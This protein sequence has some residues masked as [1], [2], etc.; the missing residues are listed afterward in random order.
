MNRFDEIVQPVTAFGPSA[1]TS[2]IGFYAAGPASAAASD[3]LTAQNKYIQKVRSC[4]YSIIITRLLSAERL[5][6]EIPA[7]DPRPLLVCLEMTVPV[8]IIA[9]LVVLTFTTCTVLS[10]DCSCAP[11]FFQKVYHAGRARKSIVRFE[12][13]KEPPSYVTCDP[14]FTERVYYR[15]V[16]GYSCMTEYL[17]RPVPLL[18]EPACSDRDFYDDYFKRLGMTATPAGWMLQDAKASILLQVRPNVPRL[19]TLEPCWNYFENLGYK[20]TGGREAPRGRAPTPPTAFGTVPSRRTT[21]TARVCSRLTL[22]DITIKCQLVY[23]QVYKTTLSFGCPYYRINADP[24]SQMS[25]GEFSTHAHSSPNI[26]LCVSK[27]SGAPLHHPRASLHERFS[28]L[29]VHSFLD[30]K[31]YCESIFLPKRSATNW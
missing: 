2:F 12:C 16:S 20:H 29:S 28:S 8:A 3:T 23:L 19:L 24:L 25:N 9:A 27:S 10:T 15:T 1:E 17:A 6:L 31:S 7:A 5:G 30:Q 26:N 18:E 22:E 4:M 21:G 11:F 13:A 14:T